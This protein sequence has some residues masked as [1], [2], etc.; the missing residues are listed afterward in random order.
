MRTGITINHSLVCNQTRMG[1]H[2]SSRY[3]FPH[4]S[5]DSNGGERQGTYNYTTL[6]LMRIL[7]TLSGCLQ[8]HHMGIN[9]SRHGAAGGKDALEFTQAVG[10]TPL[11]QALEAAQHQS[12]SPTALCTP[13]LPAQISEAFPTSPL[14]FCVSKNWPRTY[15]VQCHMN[16]IPKSKG[17]FHEVNQP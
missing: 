12:S 4:S 8:C 15:S 16:K 1:S 11:Q 13:K 2:S 3:I 9:L 6:P 5:S 14:L 10:S 17:S 7:Q